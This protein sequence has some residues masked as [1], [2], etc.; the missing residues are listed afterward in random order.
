MYSDEDY[1]YLYKHSKRIRYDLQTPIILR[2]GK[3]QCLESNK[4]HVFSDCHFYEGVEDSI[5]SNLSIGK[6]IE[7]FTAALEVTRGI[8][9][10]ISEKEFTLDVKDGMMHYYPKGS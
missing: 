3:I 1:Q 6:D 2:K 10:S 8:D 7:I 4:N 9:I 5:I